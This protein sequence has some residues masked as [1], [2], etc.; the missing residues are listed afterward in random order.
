MCCFA[1]FWPLE[2][3]SLPLSLCNIHK[4]FCINHQYFS[5]AP[6]RSF[7]CTAFSS[8][9]FLHHVR[10]HLSPYA[11]TCI[12]SPTASCWLPPQHDPS[13]SSPTPIHLLDTHLCT[14]RMLLTSW[15]WLHSSLHFS[16]NPT[17][18]CVYTLISFLAPFN[19]SEILPTSR[20]CINQCP[21]FPI[22][23]FLLPPAT[24]SHQ[25]LTRSPP[26]SHPGNTTQHALLY[27]WPPH[28]H[29]PPHNVTPIFISLVSIFSFLLF[30]KNTHKTH[31]C[32]RTLIF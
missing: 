3:P 12:S 29:I 6:T 2:S 13:S 8:L 27:Q 23:P 17:R 31:T 7:P 19:P 32:T 20:K 10:A 16:H 14:Y 15:S 21:I 1:P 18:P 11:Y 5:A 22:S 24:T 30:N 25:S 4:L 26:H 28:F 9:S